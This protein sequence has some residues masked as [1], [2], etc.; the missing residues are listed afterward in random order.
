M[1]KSGLMLIDIPVFATIIFLVPMLYLLLASPAF[2]FVSLEIPQVAT[3]M[4]SVF[5]GYFLVLV[6][7]GLVAAALFALDGLLLHSVC[8]GLVTLLDV[9]WRQWMMPRVDA[10]VAASQ[11]GVAGK[12]HR[13]RRLHLAGMATNALQL[14]ITLPFIPALVAAT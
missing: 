11:G 10:A 3:I 9:L 13:L 8:I 4:R 6:A 7:A 14:A 5:F 12:G 2:L 1:G